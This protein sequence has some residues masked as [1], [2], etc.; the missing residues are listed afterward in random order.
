MNLNTLV[1]GLTQNLTWKKQSIYIQNKLRKLNYLFFHFKKYLNSKHLTTLYR[2]LYES[3]M[4]YGVIHWG[5]SCHIKPVKVLQNKV[6]RTIH[7]LHKRTS[8]TEIY[9][10]MKALR[11]QDLCKRRLA[12]FVFK[13]KIDFQVQEPSSHLRTGGQAASYPKRL[14][15]HSRMQARYKGAE[16][17]NSLALQYRTEKTISKFKKGLLGMDRETVRTST[18]ID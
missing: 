8:E 18:S 3:T 14:K 16:C 9:S 11:L 15:T 7:Q 10:Q 4:S 13:R 17:F 6:C 1:C 12:L 2:A 5:S